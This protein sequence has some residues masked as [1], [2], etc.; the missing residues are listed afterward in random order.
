MAPALGPL[1]A[2]AATTIAALGAWRV[3]KA[4]NASQYDGISNIPCILYE[5]TN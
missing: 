4:R 2:A 3:V 1:I 5:H